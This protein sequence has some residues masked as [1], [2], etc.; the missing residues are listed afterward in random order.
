MR[1]K[2]KPSSKAFAADVRRQLSILREKRGMT[3]HELA[4][5][6]GID[7][8]TVNRIEN[9]HFSPSM[10]TFFRICGALGAKPADVLRGKRK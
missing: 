9:G 5:R 7:R 6:S 1:T 4:K 3:Q 2:P 10:D 8:K